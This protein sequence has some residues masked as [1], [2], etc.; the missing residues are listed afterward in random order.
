MKRPALMRVGVAMVLPVVLATAAAATPSAAAHTPTVARPAVAATAA[1]SLPPV[2]RAVRPT[3]H[4]FH[5]VPRAP[6]YRVAAAAAVTRSPISVK[7]VSAGHARASSVRVRVSVSGAAVARARGAGIVWSL[8]PTVRASIRVTLDLATI[9]PRFGGGWGPRARLVALVPCAG[10]ALRR[11][12]GCRLEVPVATRNVRGRVL[13]AT[14]AAGPSSAVTLA[15]VSSATG[16]AGSYAA[17]AMV[18]SSSW[19]A[20]GQ[21]GD[22]RWSYPIQAPPVA[23]GLGPTLAIDYASGSVDGRVASTNVQPSWLGQGFG[24][25]P[26]YIE[27]RYVSCAD[28]LASGNNATHATPDL[29]W[30]SMNASISLGTHSGI[31]V[32]TTTANVYRLQE[33]DGSRITHVGTGP[34]GGAAESWK[35]ETTDGTVY[36]F[37]LGKDALGNATGSAWSVPVFGNQAGEPCYKAANFAGSSCSLGW[38]WNL[39]SVVDRHGNAIGYAY[40]PETNEYGANLNTSIVSYTRGGVLTQISYGQRVGAPALGASARVVFTTAQRCIPSGTITCAATQL[41]ATTASSWPDV[42]FDQICTAALGAVPAGKGCPN[43]Q[44]PAFFTRL[45]LT[46][47]ATQVALTANVFTAVDSWAFAHTWLNPGDTTSA[48]LWLDSITRTGLDGGSVAVP[49]VKLIASTQMPNRVD[50]V[51]DNAPP[52]NN[53]RLIGIQN[54]VGGATSIVY[55]SPVEAG[56]CTPASKPVPATNTRLCFPVYWSAFGNVAP[57]LNW[58]YKYVV[59]QVTEDTGTIGST[60]KV[61]RYAYVGGGA[62]RFDRDDLVPARYRTWGQWRGFA[63]VDAVVGTPRVGPFSASRQLFMRGMNGDCV[64]ATCVAKKSVVVT[65]SRGGSVVDQDRMNGFLR[66]QIMFGAWSDATMAGSAAT[67][68]ELQTPILGAVTATDGTHSAQLLE[69]A[70]SSK[71][72]YR[73]TSGGYLESDL[74]YTYDA[75]GQPLTIDDN[76]G[77]CTTFTYDT[78]LAVWLVDLVTSKAIVAR[79]CATA[80]SATVA[81]TLSATRTVYDSAPS[82]AAAPGSAVGDPTRTLVLDGPAAGPGAWVTN[83]TTTFDGLGRPLVVTDGL[84][85]ATTTTYTPAVS[86]PATQVVVANALG[87]ATT[88]TL[89]PLRGLTLATVDPNGRRIDEAYDGLGRLTSVWLAN[90]AKA[91]QTPNVRYAY[92]LSATAGSVVESDELRNNG[93]YTAT[94]TYYDGLMR[95]TET[96]SPLLDGTAGRVVYQTLYDGRGLK[97]TVTGPVGLTGAPAATGTVI[98]ADN[99]VMDRVDTSYDVSG[100][101]TSVTERPGTPGGWRY[102]TTSTTYDGDTVT[103]TPPTGGTITRTTVDARGNTISSAQYDGTA[104]LT[105]T[106]AYRPD[107]LMTSMTDPAGKSWT[108]SYDLRGRLVSTADPDAGT[109]RFTYDVAGQQLTRTDARGV[110]ITTSYDGLGRRTGEQRTDGPTPVPLTQFTYDAATG[111]IGQLATETR[112]VNGNDY[113]QAITAY[114]PRYNVLTSQTTIPASEGLLAGTFPGKSAYN[115]DGQLQSY[116]PPNVPGLAAVGY[117]YGYDTL[118]QLKSMATGVGAIVPGVL[119]DYLGDVYQMTTG[120]SLGQGVTYNWNYE[121]GTNRLVGR[122]IQRQSQPGYTM[123]LSYT[124][125]DAGN[126]TSSNDAPSGVTDG[127]TG[128][129]QCYTYDGLRRLTAAWTPAAASCA[130]APASAAALGGPAPYWRTYGYNNEGSRTSETDNAGVTPTT[131]SYQYA[132]GAPHELASTTTGGRTTGYGFDAAGNRTTVTPP[133][134]Q[135]TTTTF[136][137]FGKVSSVTSAAG[138]VTYIHDAEGRLLLTKVG[139]DETLSLPDGTEDRVTNAVASSTRSISFLGN[140]VTVQTPGGFVNIVPDPHNTGELA[141]D[142]HTDAISIRRSLPF[143]GL[144]TTPTSWPDQHGFVGGLADPVAVTGTVHVGARDYDSGTGQFISPDPVL[145]AGNPSGWNPYAYGGS[146]PVTNS[147]PS[148]LMLASPDGGGGGGLTAT[149]PRPAPAKPRMIVYGRWAAI[150]R[151]TSGTNKHSDSGGSF[152]SNIGN[153]FAGMGAG[154]ADQVGLGDVYTGAMKSAGVD[155]SSGWYT[156][157]RTVTNVAIIVASVAV[158]GVGAVRAGIQAARLANDAHE[159]LNAV[160]AGESML[161]E[162]ESLV[163]DAAESCSAN[164]FTARTLVTMADGSREPISRVAVG[165]RVLASDPETG[166]T[167]GRAVTA[168]IVHGGAHT[169]VD[170]RL[171]DGTTTTATDHHPFWDATTTSFVYADHLHVGDR[172]L[173]ANGTLIQVSGLRIYQADVTAY[174]LAI[175]GIHTYYAGDTPVL[176]HNTCG[177]LVIGENISRV[178]RFADEVGGHA[179]RPWTRASE[180][181]ALRRNERMVRDAMS[182]GRDIIDIGPDFARRAAGREPSLFYNMERQVTRGYDRYQRVWDRSGQAGGVPGFDP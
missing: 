120:A 85:R 153:A 91:T 127:P 75:Y 110:Q 113:T 55:S 36:T 51:T 126:V 95:E 16:S 103:V 175:D 104:F 90:R 29:C 35:L 123:N 89:D 115:V 21:S 181:V 32:P 34:T 148:G 158:P 6:R 130:A 60:Q 134:G 18:P 162:A 49:P 146:N 107:G 86:G 81:D 143:G 40:A 76:A 167:E 78:N 177:P 53:F 42:P 180:S 37:G 92:T 59:R 74:A 72:T 11:D 17:T 64:D 166:R 138:T 108:R 128:E 93:T 94:F 157:A 96:Q 28:D 182:A 137:E 147:D 45:M 135:A 82:W 144:R 26:G 140:A 69:T 68:E 54:N 156:G 15:A 117:S 12:P 61:T 87:Q 141:I 129:T 111:G 101:V 10:A 70:S 22:F 170:V 50:S 102:L 122:I 43:V 97:A 151:S 164:S 84:G 3:T 136:D 99:Q 171:A 112:T 48:V 132:A 46:G 150:Y 47:I 8:R 39:D 63:T 67:S 121:T 116:I 41:T 168:T 152:F 24:L 109:T 38:R 1:S 100:R 30:R 52:M 149:A 169:M 133:V 131:T 25:E 161:P 33:D 142:D 154:V 173:E 179:Y 57:S 105:S 14:V 58:F 71:R 79:P 27:R 13:V 4:P 73:T 83:A 172:L 159:A 66:E 80:P 119:H 2:V 174:N 124:Y 56:A 5:L 163:R 9:A 31:L 106:Y 178:R 176:V 114:D 155:T 145:D 125:D 20:G 19:Q 88:T 160:R 7:V 165:D 23:G 98:A 118:G 139:T 44:A 65:D 62:W 77:E